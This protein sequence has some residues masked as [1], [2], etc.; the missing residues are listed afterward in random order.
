MSADPAAHPEDPG[1]PPPD[2]SPNPTAPHPR[3]S[4]AKNISSRTGYTWTGLVIASIVGLLLLIFVLQNL[5]SMRVHL[6]FW[7]FSLP[8]GVGALL[9]AIGGALIMAIVGGLRMLQLRRA[10]KKAFTAAS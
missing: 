6:L 5:T 3:H 2:G 1:T 8:L 4:R 10:A 9:A 7:W